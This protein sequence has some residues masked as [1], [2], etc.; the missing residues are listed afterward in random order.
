MPI[1]TGYRCCKVQEVDE[2]IGRLC[3]VRNTMQELVSRGCT[4]HAFAWIQ[5]R[6]TKWSPQGKE[7]FQFRAVGLASSSCFCFPFRFIRSEEL[8]YGLQHSI[9]GGF[10]ETLNHCSYAILKQELWIPLFFSIVE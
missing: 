1:K 10:H 9:F 3:K 7:G 8:G 2:L 5:K 6:K 4:F